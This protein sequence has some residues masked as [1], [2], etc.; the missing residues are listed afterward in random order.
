M[1]KKVTALLKISRRIDKVAALSN[2]VGVYDLLIY[3]NHF[4]NVHK[5]GIL[6]VYQ[7][8]LNLPIFSLTYSPPE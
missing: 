2:K 5:S 3:L 4:K 7:K 6:A 1:M 8:I